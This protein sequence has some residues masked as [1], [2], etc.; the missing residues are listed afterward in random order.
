MTAIIVAAIVVT[1][2]DREYRGGSET[3]RLRELLPL[4]FVCKCGSIG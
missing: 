1:G 3:E 2:H 4:P